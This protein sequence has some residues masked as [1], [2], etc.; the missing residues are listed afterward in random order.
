MYSKTADKVYCV[1]CM[2]FSGLSGSENWAGNGY[3]DWRNGGRDIVLHESSPEHKRAEI[4]ELQWRQGMIVTKMIDRNPVFCYRRQLQGHGMRTRQHTLFGLRDDCN[5]GQHL[6][7]GQIHEPFQVDGKHDSYAAAY[8]L[9]TEMEQEEKKKMS[10]NLISPR[11]HSS[12]IS[13]HE[14]AYPCND[15]A[16]GAAVKKGLHN[17]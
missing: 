12:C 10:V 16:T 9:K 8:L 5:L 3:S 15:Y 7:R 1:S 13:N 11:K 2:A 14:A 17:F 6:Q 4:A